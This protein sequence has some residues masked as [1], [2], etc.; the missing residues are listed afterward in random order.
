MGETP[1]LN[2]PSHCRLVTYIPEIPNAELSSLHMYHTA[3]GGMATPVTT[4][5]NVPMLVG[6]VSHNSFQTVIDF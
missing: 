4:I 3:K 2:K 5:L 6:K 1:R